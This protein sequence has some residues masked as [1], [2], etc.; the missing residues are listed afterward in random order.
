[1]EDLEIGKDVG[2]YANTTS[3]HLRDLST[4]ALGTQ[5][6]PA[7]EYWDLTV[8]SLQVQRLYGSLLCL[9][10]LLRPLPMTPP[11]FSS[12][13]YTRSGSV[14]FLGSNHVF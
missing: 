14:K 11:H 9:P 7:D 8:E 3:F 12:S 5:R 10:V 13:L 2:V 6:G 1:M 4:G